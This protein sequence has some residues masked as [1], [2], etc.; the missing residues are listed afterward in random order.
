MQFETT[1]E[2]IK[3]LAN[4]LKAIRKSRKI[5]QQ[6]LSIISNVSL[7]SIKRFELTGEISLYSLVK[8]C[9]ALDLT[10]EI[11]N[12]FKEVRFNSIEEVIRYGK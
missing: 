4:R 9:N 7:G 12:L 8:L 1:E 2:I 5:S 3:N 10:Y 6:E 11:D